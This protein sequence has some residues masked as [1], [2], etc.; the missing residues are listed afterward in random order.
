[1][2]R[3]NLFIRAVLLGGAVLA[4]SACGDKEQTLG[5]NIKQDATPYSGTGKPY[6][7]PGWKAGDKVSWEQQLRTRAQN[8]QNDYTRTN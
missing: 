5:S 2:S 1:M 8:G 7:A 6:A 4:L 3:L